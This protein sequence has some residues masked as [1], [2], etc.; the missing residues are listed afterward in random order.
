M[1]HEEGLY[2]ERLSGKLALTLADIDSALV[3]RCGST[4]YAHVAPVLLNG[5]IFGVLPS[6]GA[7]VQV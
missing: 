7:A 4:G 5:G 6:Q 1:A 3:V 2:S